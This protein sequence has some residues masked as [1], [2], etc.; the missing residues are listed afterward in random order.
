[1]NNG[2]INE[3]KQDMKRLAIFTDQQKK[4]EKTP[5]TWFELTPAQIKAAQNEK[6]NFKRV[7]NFA[8][9]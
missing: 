5:I 4:N 7:I 8:K 2:Q 9:L 1:M 3:E 6:K